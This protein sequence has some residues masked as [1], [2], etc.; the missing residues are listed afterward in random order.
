MSLGNNIF[1][2]RSQAN[3]SQEE[4]AAKL[5]VSRQSVS[6]WETD[7][8]VPDVDKLIQLS[9]IF[10]V[11]L[12]EL[13]N[14]EENQQQAETS[15]QEATKAENVVSVK[16]SPLRTRKIV[17][18]VLI[19]VSLLAA[20]LSLIFPNDLIGIVL[21]FSFYFLLCGLLCLTVK[22]RL[23]LAIILMS[24]VYIILTVLLIS[25]TMM[26]RIDYDAT[27]VTSVSLNDI[28]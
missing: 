23:F 19:G 13:V 17:G 14:G 26:V 12:D 11:T 4:L 6:K 22:K 1:N 3:F 15:I 7:A 24:A 27:E 10:G 16:S 18:A 8:S 5:G 21:Y 2:L 28:Q 9:K 25:M 20:F